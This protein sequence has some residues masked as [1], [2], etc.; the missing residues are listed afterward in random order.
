MRGARAR[1][2][3]GVR[4]PSC[5]RSRTPTCPVVRWLLA[6]GTPLVAG[7]LISRLSPL[8]AGPSERAPELRERRGAHAARARHA[9]PTR[10]SRST[11]TAIITQLE[12]GGR[13]DVRLDGGRGDRRDDARAD[14]AAGVRATATTSA[15]WRWSTAPT[16]SPPRPTRSSSRGAT[17]AAS[18]ARR[19]CRRSTSR[20]ELF[21]SGLHHATSPSGCAGRP[22]ARRCC[23]SRPRARR[24]SGWRSWSAACRLLVDAALAHRTLE[25]HPA[26][27]RDQ[28]RGVLDADAA[29]I[30]LAD[31]RGR[32][33]PSAG[34]AS[35]SRGAAAVRR[36]LR[37]TRGGAARADAAPGPE[38]PSCPTPSS[39]R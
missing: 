19:P 17:A 29:T 13:A 15:D 2:R 6:V 23:A 33:W 14:H 35:P 11:A 9:H 1:G 12:R 3:I 37:R 16:R 10:S 25:R 26:R 36:G 5:S 28:V 38:P 4:T 21:V 8:R 30:Y 34:G 27:P 39:R 32:R 22:S 18:R 7:L 24:P 31:D 20:G